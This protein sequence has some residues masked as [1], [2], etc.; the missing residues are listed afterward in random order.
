M[1]VEPVILDSAREHG[2]SDE[3]MQH[4]Y[5]NTIWTWEQDEGFVMHTGPAWN[6]DLLEIGVVTSTE[7]IVLIIHAMKARPKYLR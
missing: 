7:G 3:D 4:A 1:S 5:R 6:S 2:V